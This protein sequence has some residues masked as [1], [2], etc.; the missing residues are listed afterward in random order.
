MDYGKLALLKI[1]DMERLLRDGA[2]R[3][4]GLRMIVFELRGEGD[5]A[6]FSSH[7]ET[8]VS[9]EGSLCAELSFFSESSC[10]CSIS[11]LIGGVPFDAKE[12][13]LGG[14]CAV[15]FSGEVPK[16][17]HSLKV[18][19]EALSGQLLGIKNLFAK[20]WGDVAYAEYE[21]KLE[22]FEHGGFV[23]AAYCDSEKVRLAVY[24]GGD[25][26]ITDVFQKRG[27]FSF[28]PITH[29]D[30]QSY[31]LLYFFCDEGKLYM[32]VLPVH[33]AFSQYRQLIDEESSRIS[34]AASKSPCGALL[35]YLKGGSVHIR[36][37]A[38]EGGKVK[39]SAPF[40]VVPLPKAYQVSAVKGLEKGIG[41]AVA[42][43]GANGRMYLSRC[44]FEALPDEAVRASVRCFI[45]GL[46]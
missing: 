23:R 25:F 18:A 22:A 14:G 24:Y 39:V 11:L 2:K 10:R 33:S 13:E 29:P 26:L 21:G 31:D 4:G 8:F 45:E 44:G 19:F 5:A 34:C 17:R 41:F 32:H 16:G 9:G 40:A 28:C 15:S 43:R 27:D 42:E 20:L 35:Y 37:I 1:E 36:H 30:G 12:V 3:D 46:S 7:E 38:L 6:S